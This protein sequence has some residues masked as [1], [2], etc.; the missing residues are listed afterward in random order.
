MHHEEN[1]NP[2]PFTS[3][4]MFSMMSSNPRIPTLKTYQDLKI[5]KNLAIIEDKVLPLMQFS[6]CYMYIE[7]WRSK[8]SLVYFKMLKPLL[9]N[10]KK[11][12][13]M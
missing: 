4:N 11:Q 6:Q 7:R 9:K 8:T 1:K 10:N 5:P 12:L 3:L 2:Y 13:H